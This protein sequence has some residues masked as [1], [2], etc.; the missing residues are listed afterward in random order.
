MELFGYISYFLVIVSALVIQE[1]RSLRSH[2]KKY[3]L[4]KKNGT[5]FYH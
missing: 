5:K 2:L 4:N 3:L 1:P